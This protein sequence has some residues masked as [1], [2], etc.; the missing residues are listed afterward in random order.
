MNMEDVCDY[1]IEGSLKGFKKIV[2]D[3][4]AQKVYQKQVNTK[5]EV[6]HIYYY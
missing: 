1:M 2:T 3:D 6:T 4:S 5:I